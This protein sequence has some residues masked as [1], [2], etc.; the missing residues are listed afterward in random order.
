MPE[1]VVSISLKNTLTIGLMLLATL[2]V[3]HFISGALGNRSAD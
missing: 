2:V 1:T 3:W